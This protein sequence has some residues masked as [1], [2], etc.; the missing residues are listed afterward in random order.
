MAFQGTQTKCTACSKTVY[1]VDKLTAD[2]RI[3]HKACFKCHHCKGTLKVQSLSASLFIHLF[4]MSIIIVNY[5]IVPSSGVILF[6]LFEVLNAICHIDYLWLPTVLGAVS[7][8]A[9]IV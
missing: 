7:L 2:N 1:L 4:I 3:Y 9:R 5:G 8:Q 6:D